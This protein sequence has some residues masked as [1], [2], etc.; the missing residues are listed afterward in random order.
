VCESS[1]RTRSLSKDLK[2]NPDVFWS[3]RIYD[4]RIEITEPWLSGGAARNP[5]GL[6]R[7]NS[8]EWVIHH[9]IYQTK[10]GVQSL[11]FSVRGCKDHLFT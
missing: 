6:R 4:A 3:V 1:S 9:N 5:L 2:G 8:P 10:E 11:H 7:R